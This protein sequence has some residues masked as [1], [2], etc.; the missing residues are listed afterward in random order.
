MTRCTGVIGAAV[1]T[2]GS[3]SSRSRDRLELVTRSPYSKT[4][5]G[6]NELKHKD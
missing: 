1:S 5:L 4:I 6:T 2:G 3:P